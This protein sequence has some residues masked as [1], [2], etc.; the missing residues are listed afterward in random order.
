MK[1]SLILFLLLILFPATSQLF[2]QTDYIVTITG[3]SISNVTITGY[4]VKPDLFPNVYNEKIN[5]K[6]EDLH[7]TYQ[8]LSGKKETENFSDVKAFS[9]KNVRIIPWHA[10]PLSYNEKGKIEFTKILEVPGK[11][12][13]QLYNSARSFLITTFKLTGDAIS[14]ALIE[15]KEN[16]MLSIARVQDEINSNQPYNSPKFNSWI[17]YSITIRVKDGKCKITVT[18]FTHHYEK[19]FIF[20]DKMIQKLESNIEDYVGKWRTDGG[21]IKGHLYKGYMQMFYC[22]EDKLIAGFEKSILQKTDDNW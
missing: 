20:N 7:I 1:N 4:P 14:Q 10:R 3:D 21:A 12:K 18:D 11:T 9:V 17:T 8:T 6:Y 16:G 15:D 22:A 5:K 19:G 2:A 13:E